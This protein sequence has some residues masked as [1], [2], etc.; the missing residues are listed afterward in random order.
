MRA[1]SL[2]VSTAERETLEVINGG[3]QGNWNPSPPRFLDAFPL[4]FRKQRGQF[5][6]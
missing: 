6:R 4:P 1:C 3:E 2:F 5:R